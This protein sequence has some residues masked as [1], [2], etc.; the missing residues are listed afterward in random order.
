MLSTSVRSLPARLVTAAK[1]KRAAQLDHVHV[2][3]I[4]AA[5]V[6][7]RPRI[8]ASGARTTPNM[9]RLPPASPGTIDTASTL[10]D[11]QALVKMY[12]NFLFPRQDAHCTPHERSQNRTSRTRSRVWSPIQALRC[13][14]RTQIVGLDAGNK[15]MTTN[16]Q[17]STELP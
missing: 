6:E 8:P 15:G 17:T 13:I 1:T 12:T 4:A 3:A 9:N 5:V 2:L 11:R 10:T 16:W 14:I 7:R